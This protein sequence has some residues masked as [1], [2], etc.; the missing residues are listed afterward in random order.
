MF[1]TFSV[2]AMYCEELL[3]NDIARIG[4]PA[5][6][7]AF[8]CMRFGQNLESRAILRGPAAENT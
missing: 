3:K 2:V 4:T 1:L 8:C 7:C 6:I 5:Y